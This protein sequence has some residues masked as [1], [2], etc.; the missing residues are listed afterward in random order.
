MTAAQ[1]R[2]Q[3]RMLAPWT[4]RAFTFKRLPSLALWRVR[5]AALDSTRCAVTIPYGWR[6]QNPFRSTYFAAQAGA[7][8][9]S[10]GALVMLHLE[11][12]PSCSM[13]VTDFESKYYKK[14][15]S[16]L[17]CTCLD[18]PALAAAVAGTRAD[19]EAR[20]VRAYSSGHLD[21]GTLASEFWVTWSLRRR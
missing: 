5:V 11:G 13:L 16:T 4:W 14:V 10:T 21:D 19:G 1:T 2:L 12:G 18:G 15:S 8:E 6:T 9:L 17:T 3:R 7:A 20:T